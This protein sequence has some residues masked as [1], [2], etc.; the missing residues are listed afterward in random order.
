MYIQI[1]R[2][3]ENDIEGTKEREKGKE[4]SRRKE[5]SRHMGKGISETGRGTRETSK[6]K[7]K[8]VKVKV[9]GFGIAKKWRT[10]D[11]RPVSKEGKAKSNRK[12]RGSRQASRQP[13]PTKIQPK[14]AMPAKASQSQ[15]S[16]RKPASQPQP[17]EIHVQRETK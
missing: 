2:Q 13:K 10:R 7:E 1:E 5:S 3:I 11:K 6:G 15:H 16:Q 14:L 12:R 4:K 9:T 17:N 8:K